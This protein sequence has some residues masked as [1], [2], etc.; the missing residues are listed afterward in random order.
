MDRYELRKAQL[1]ALPE[2]PKPPELPKSRADVL[3]ESRRDF[4]SFYRDLNE[5]IA[6]RGA[7]VISIENTMETNGYGRVSRFATLRF[8]FS[9]GQ[10]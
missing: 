10:I 4:E 7:R 5:F 2:K 3:L 6:S 1:T 9:E 8:F